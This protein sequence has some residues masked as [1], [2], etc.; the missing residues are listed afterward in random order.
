MRS[1]TKPRWQGK[2]IP[3]DIWKLYSAYDGS[4]GLTISSSGTRYQVRI[5]DNPHFCP[6]ETIGKRICWI[7]LQVNEIQ[8]RLYRMVYGSLP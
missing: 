3:Q 1:I 2:Q 8:A 7:A 6:P 4:H 5:L